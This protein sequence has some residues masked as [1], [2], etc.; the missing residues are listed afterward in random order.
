MNIVIIIQARMGSTRLP[1]KVMLPL[2]GPTVLSHVI[3]RAKAV[4]N[5]TVVCVATSTLSADDI[6]VNES[7]RNDALF[8]QGSE[9]DVLSRYYEAALQEEADHIVRITSDCPLLD[10]QVV[11][12]IIDVHLRTGADYTSNTHQRTYPRGLDVEVFT[13]QSLKEAY[14]QADLPAQREHV[15]PFIYQNPDKY[16]MEHVLHEEDCSAHRWTLDTPE[17]WRVIQAI[18]EGLYSANPKFGWLDALQYVVSNPEIS[19]W[20]EEVEQKKL[21]G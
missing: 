20:N 18:Y 21:N 17:D 9:S 15:T 4:S 11:E 13:M 6:I 19:T 12:H 3:Q 8:Y 5:A 10:P 16:R 7:V 14:E 2:Q 1:G